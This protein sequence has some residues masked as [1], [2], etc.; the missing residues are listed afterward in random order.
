M[1]DTESA[2]ALPVVTGDAG[3]DAALA[4]AQRRLRDFEALAA[5]HPHLAGDTAAALSSAWD[6]LM[7]KLA[8]WGPMR[9]AVLGE[10]ARAA[11]NLDAASAL[12]RRA[13]EER[14]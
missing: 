12:I 6:V 2:A 8:P 3:L 14:S 1:Y 4:D 7:G 5:R 10:I 9:A 13:I 11:R